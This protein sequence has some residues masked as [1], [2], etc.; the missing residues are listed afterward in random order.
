M[1]NSIHSKN[2]QDR[3]E[4]ELIQFEKSFFN[5]KVLP[6]FALLSSYIRV[7]MDM[8][9]SSWH[10]QSNDKDLKVEKKPHQN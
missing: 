8:V 3:K 2:N 7:A 6:Y 10:K 4:E 5:F 9:S 1:A